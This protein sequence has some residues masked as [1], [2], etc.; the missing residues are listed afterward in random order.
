VDLPGIVSEPKA[1]AEATRSLTQ[2]ML[3]MEHALVLAVVSGRSESLRNYTIWEL[4]REANKP[5]VMVLTKIDVGGDYRF[6]ER[7]AGMG[8]IPQDAGVQRVVPVVN[9]DSAS[10][11]NA[12]ATLQSSYEYESQVLRGVYE[13]HE[14][15]SDC[16]FGM[17]GVLEAVNDMLYRYMC[18]EW[19]DRETDSLE[20]EL[21]EIYTALWALGLRPSLI[22]S[23]ITLL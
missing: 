17:P 9:R 21:G 1:A 14:V 20:I 22:S 18:T 3:A 12:H 13:D 8:D 4:L 15:N 16:A 19:V 7:L 6:E 23:R 10:K 2:K 11:K 5:V